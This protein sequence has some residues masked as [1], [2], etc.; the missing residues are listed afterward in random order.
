M[1][2]RSGFLAAALTGL[3]GAMSRPLFTGASAPLMPRPGP[4][5]NRRTEHFG[6]RQ[7][8]RSRGGTMRP[9]RDVGI[10]TTPAQVKINR[11]TNWQ[12]T[13]WSRAGCKERDIDTYLEMK[14]RP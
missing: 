2:N 3:I 9:S 5:D 1:F 14:R 4:G 6:Y 8:H 10:F 13:Q 11:M 7:S 12:A